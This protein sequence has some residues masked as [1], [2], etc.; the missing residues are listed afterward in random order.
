LFQGRYKAILVEEEGHHR[1]LSRYIHLNPVRAGMARQP[2]QWRWSSCAAY[3]RGRR[4]P[5]W[6]T[7]ERVLAEFGA[8]ESATRAAYRRFLLDADHPAPSPLRGVAYG[9]ILGSDRFVARICRL[10]APVPDNPEQPALRR[11][12]NRPSVERIA[13]VV[14]AHFALDP[15]GWR[16][17]RRS[18]HIGRAL[19]AYLA[20]RRYGH[21]ASETARALGYGRSSSIAQACERVERNLARLSPALKHVE[22]AL[23]TGEA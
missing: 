13:A 14:A 20:R 3:F 6:L 11:M 10:L 15:A 7:C 18:D 1:E 9:F 2:E 5:P 4:T 12:R 8:D 17:G 21:S 19:A 23:G 22:T 16:R